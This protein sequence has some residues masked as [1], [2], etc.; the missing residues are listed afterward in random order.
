MHVPLASKIPVINWI[1]YSYLLILQNGDYISMNN[2]FY[3]QQLYKLLINKTFSVF[4]VNDW[5]ALFLCSVKEKVDGFLYKQLYEEKLLDEIPKPIRKQLYLSYIYNIKKNQMYMTEFSNLQQKLKTQ[6]ICVYPEKGIYLIRTI[7]K[8]IGTRYM[9]DI[10]ILAWIFNYEQ[11]QSIIESMGYTLTLIN[12]HAAELYQEG[13]PILSCLF[14]KNSALPY[15][16]PFAKIDVTYSI[17]SNCSKQPCY[18]PHAETLFRLCKSLYNSTIENNL[19]PV[20]INCD[21]GKLLD[22]IFYSTISQ[23]KGRYT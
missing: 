6:D 7:Y 20:P 11:I 19:E 12:D 18:L 16:M 22:I 9:E 14:Q 2:S 5:Y 17:S 1:I 4:S 15:P 21:L 23:C 10:D 8:D 3:K 13:T